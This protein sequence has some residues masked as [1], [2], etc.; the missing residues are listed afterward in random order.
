MALLVPHEGDVQLLTDLLG[1]GSLEN[2]QLGL[3]NS[4]ITP[5]ETDTASTYTAHETAFTSYA[6]KTL[7][8]SI[9]SSTWNTPVSQAPSGISGLVQPQPGRPQ[10]VRQ[11]GPVVDL[12][13]DRRHDLRLLHHRCHQRQADLRRGVRHAAHAGQRRHALH[14]A[15]LRE[16]L[17]HGRLY[18]NNLRELDSIR[19]LGRPG[20]SWR[21]RHRHDRHGHDRHG[22]P[23]YHRGKQ[24]RRSDHD[25]RDH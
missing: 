19:H 23:E 25:G 6:R 22:G 12:R 7:T 1:G 9:G 15:D 4:N 8:R 3:F 10:P 24:P 2:W 5:A 13:R 20:R 11:L 21:Q 17:I 18:F 16:R 14:H